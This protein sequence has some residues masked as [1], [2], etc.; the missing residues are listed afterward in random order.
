[1]RYLIKFTSLLVLG[2]ITLQSC[3][4]ENWVLPPNKFYFQIIKNGTPLNSITLDSLKL[5]YYDGNEKIYSFPN[6]EGAE[7][8]RHIRKPSMYSG[9]S[10]EHAIELEKNDIR[11]CGY[12]V[13]H[14][15]YWY[16][17]F[18]DGD[19]DTLYITTKELSNKEGMKDPCYCSHPFITVQYN[20]K[21]ATIHPT[22]KAGD[23]K[24]IYVLEKQ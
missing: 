1:M 4:K 6:A 21:D 20:G 22:L 17:Q 8:G 3:K 24:N 13:G 5:Y 10:L 12:I 19:I 23:G 15:G 18:P 11:V 16:Y 14:E 7:T 2:I 9:N